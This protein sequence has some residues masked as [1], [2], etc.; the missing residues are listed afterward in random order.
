MSTAAVVAGSL[1][2]AGVGAAA[3]MSAAG[4]QAD[5]AKSAAQLQYQESQNALDFQ[6]QEYEQQQANEAPFIKAG[7]GAVNTLSTY[8]PFTAPTLEE[9]KAQPGY[10]FALQ[11]GENAINQNAA[12]TGNVY[13]GTTLRAADQ[14][15]QNLA[16]TN[17][18]NVYNRSLGTYETNLN[19]LQSLAGEGLTGTGQAAAAGGQAASNI[20]NI[21]M[22][23]GAQIGQDIQN[24]GAAEASGYVG[25]ANAFGGMT[26]SLSQYALLNK[27][28][29]PPFDPG[30]L[31]NLPPSAIDPTTGL[32]TG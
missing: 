12:A 20:G 1:A 3:S 28:L 9:A 14:F 4:T 16:E 27:M 30:S 2:S 17:Y 19:R 8:A 7:Q 5:A 6:K 26:N 32:P 10:Q 24:A 29:N 25:A 18:G 22:A 15:A 21:N 13:S 31:P 11:E 23:T